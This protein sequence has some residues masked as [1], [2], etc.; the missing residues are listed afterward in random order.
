M[1]MPN[2]SRHALSLAVV[3]LVAACG[4]DESPR[5][6]GQAFA[7]A[8]SPNIASSD[9]LRALA[10]GTGG[11]TTA[12][13]ASVA[14]TDAQLFQGAEALFPDLFPSPQTA[15][16][17]TNLAYDNKIFQVKLYR[18]GNYLGVGNDGNVYGLGPY[19]NGVLVKFDAKQAYA[20]LVCSKI[21]CGTSTGGGGGSLNECAGPSLSTLATGFKTRS[22]FLYS[23]LI[24]GEQT[25][26]TELKGSTTFEGQTATETLATTKGSNTIQGFTVPITTTSKV[27]TQAGSNGLTKTIGALVDAVTGGFNVGGFT[28]PDT[29]ISSKVV[30]NPPIENTEFTLQLGQSLTK[31][32]ATST[33]IVSS[34]LGV[35]APG[36]V[37]TGTDTT[38]WTFEAKESITVPAGTYSTCRYSATS[39]G[40]TLGKT[41]FIVGKGMLAKS[42]TV[43]TEGTQK[44]ELKSGTFGGAPL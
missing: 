9:R 36:T 29:T 35:P 30:Y 15:E 23:G 24:S 34:S 37:T 4:G 2:I 33:T 11:G 19:T 39:A 28:T 41:W 7:D 12:G 5:S 27:Y 1:T 26:E 6:A 31:T 20:D 16:S 40:N 22:V 43:T 44:I 25:V 3:A 8:L 14:I 21:N 32:E 42:E 38:T 13:A 10:A 17:I 18:S